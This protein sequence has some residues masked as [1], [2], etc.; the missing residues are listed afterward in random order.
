MARTGIRVV[1]F[2]A[3]GLLLFAFAT[4]AEAD[5]IK[6][7]VTAAVNPDTVGQPPAAAARTMLIGADVMFKERIA[8][9]DTGQAQLLFLDQSSLTVAPKSE[10]VVDEFVY[11]PKQNVGKLA[12]S[13]T[14]G[15]MRYVGG[16]ISKESEVQ[17]ATPSAT[18]GIRGGMVLI[19]IDQVGGTVAAFL[20]GRHMEVTANGVTETV[21]RPGFTI[22]VGQP[23]Q[24]PS[25]PTPTR[26]EFIQDALLAL[27]GHPGS[28]GGAPEP[29]TD[30]GFAQSGLG[31]QLQR[32]DPLTIQS[33][34][35]A[36][37]GGPQRVVVAQ[38]PNTTSIIDNAAQNQQ[39]DTIAT[40]VAATIAT[41]VTPPPPPPPPPAGVPPPGPPPPPP[42]SVSI[43]QFEGSNHSS[44]TSIS[45]ANPRGFS[46]TFATSRGALTGALNG[47]FFQGG[48]SPVAATGG[49]FAIRNKNTSLV[50]RASG[51]FAA[52]KQ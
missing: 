51:T 20:Y 11:D 30:L 34:L 48:G 35:S 42:D 29:P 39:R 44:I 40:T 16:A 10:V 52:A 24:S 46:G 8:T 27:E 17:F 43:N 33:A 28:T 22:A 6:V 37:R 26:S 3:A 5:D 38:L 21:T 4:S 45:L 1:A 47:S 23:G 12:A 9:A 15:L 25:P 36:G 50:Y 7:G 18:V 14:K 49:Q 31:Q 19:Q 2:A 32:I 41:T 13:V